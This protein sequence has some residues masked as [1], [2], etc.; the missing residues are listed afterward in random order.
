M[1]QE[2]R[3]QTR[4]VVYRLDGSES[5]S[6]GGR[7]EMTTA[8]RWDGAALLT[9][10]TNSISTPSGDMTI[11]IQKR[12]TL[13]PDGQTMTVESTRTMPFGEMNV[14]LVYRKSS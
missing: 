4:T 3:G 11:D 8:S 9:E 14:T 12:R 1:E 13:S 5:T 6:S 2:A 10:G 7:G